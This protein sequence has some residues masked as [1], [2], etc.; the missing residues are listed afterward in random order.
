MTEKPLLFQKPDFHQGVNV[1]VRRGAKWFG[2]LEVGDYVEI[3]ATE[4]FENEG[5]TGNYG[6]HLVLGVA[7]VKD[8]DDIDSELLKF[9]HDPTCRTDDGLLKCLRE[10]YGDNVDDCGE[11]FSVV[12][13]YYGES[14]V[15]PGIRL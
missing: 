3:E 14:L 8:L 5:M 2:M 13:F 1:T 11:G 6:Y 12:V 7:F 9:E 15:G 4:G 10:V